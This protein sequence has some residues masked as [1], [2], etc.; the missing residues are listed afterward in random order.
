MNTRV[1][2]KTAD[3]AAFAE[4]RFGCLFRRLFSAGC[5]RNGAAAAAVLW[6]CLAGLP[7][8][9]ADDCL[10]GNRLQEELSR[11]RSVS[12]T[13]RPLQEVLDD[14]AARAG[15]CF[16]RDRRVDPSAPVRLTT[17]LLPTD[18]LI[19]RV[20]SASAGADI[21]VTERFVYVGPAP[22]A[23]RLRT[24]L[25]ITR[26]MFR[27]QSGKEFQKTAR[28]L[29]KMKSVIWPDLSHPA[30]IIRRTAA[31]LNLNLSDAERIPHDLWHAG[32][33][34]KMP[35][36]DALAMLLFQFDLMME[37]GSEPD[38]LRI[39]PLPDRIG[40]RRRH[41][42]PESR[43]QAIEKTLAAR[44]P[45]LQFDWTGRS[46]HVVATVE[47]HEQIER[48]LTG[49]ESRSGA[50]AESLRTQTW[51]LV[52][53]RGVTC[54]QLLERLAASGVTVRCEVD[55]EDVLDQTVQ[56]D[57]HDVPGDQFFP[58][59]FSGLPVRVDVQDDCVVLYPPDI[60]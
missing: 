50:P 19:R 3:T 56:V 38:A 54:R 13:A 40:I 55:L 5:F 9:S 30:D 39:R 48:L 29:R 53:R 15:L 25:E 44:W 23:G 60:P 33:L 24:V 49:Q 10:T 11:P 41:R 57:L 58:Q 14:L 43:Q 6:G 8:G 1:R 32:R 27:Q 42:V 26:R 22:H 12:V 2:T 35:V 31:S 36:R 46:F 18:E 37:P 45:S 47:Q 51:T 4:D 20:V 7:S 59:I 52:T 16:V 28:R 21:S 34:P 17:A